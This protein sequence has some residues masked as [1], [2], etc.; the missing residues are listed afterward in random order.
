MKKVKSIKLYLDIKYQYEGESSTGDAEGPQTQDPK[1]WYY[2]GKMYIW[3]EN[4]K[5]SLPFLEEARDTSSHTKVP[6]KA[7]IL[8]LLINCNRNELK[9]L[10]RELKYWESQKENLSKQSSDI[11]KIINFLKKVL[12]KFGSKFHENNLLLPIIFDGRQSM[13]CGY[14][15]Q[16]R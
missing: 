1:G 10:Y 5:S 14:G 11:E 7:K 15:D 16:G 4:S 3:G 12:D 8:E 9:K 13:F 2:A 6:T